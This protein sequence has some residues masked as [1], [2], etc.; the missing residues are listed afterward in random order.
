LDSEDGWL[1]ETD[2]HSYLLGCYY[3][4][5]D[6]GIIRDETQYISIFNNHTCNMDIHGKLKVL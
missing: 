4:Y 1:D 6:I 5:G 3:M 2:S